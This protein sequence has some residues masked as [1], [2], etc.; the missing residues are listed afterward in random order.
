LISRQAFIAPI[1]ALMTASFVLCSVAQAQR[2]SA[3]YRINPG[4]QLKISV[5][6]EED[7]EEEVLVLPDGGISYVLSGE[8]QAAGRTLDEL[9]R[10]ITTYVADYVSDPVVAVSVTQTSGNTIYVLGEV[11]TPG[12][13]IMNPRLDVMQALSRAGG[14]TSFAD[15]NKII[16]IRRDGDSQRVFRFSYREVAKGENLHQNILLEPGDTIVVP[17]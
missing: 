16:I 6:Q 2:T 14:T 5:W 9:Q 3:T 13:L 12:E 7:L 1:I 10:E 8:I 11:E 4:D 17:E 15:L